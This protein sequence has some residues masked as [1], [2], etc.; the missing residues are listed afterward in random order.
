MDG[1]NEQEERDALLQI[2]EAEAEAD[3]ENEKEYIEAGLV[4]YKLSK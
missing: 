2:A 1:Y 3:K 4:Y